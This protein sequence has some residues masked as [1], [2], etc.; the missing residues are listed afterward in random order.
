MSTKLEELSDLDE[1]EFEELED[2]DLELEENTDFKEDFED[3]PKTKSKTQEQPSKVVEY[4]PTDMMGT[5]Y[6]KIKEPILVTFITM[7]ITNPIFSQ[8]ITSLPYVDITLDSV[9]LNLI[10]S[11]VAGILFFIFRTF[12]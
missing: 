8:V 10:L 2:M 6:D 4:F 1:Q 7:A 11:I 5:V 9:K 12:V 3:A